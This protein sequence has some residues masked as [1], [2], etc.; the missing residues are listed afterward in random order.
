[1]EE[2]GTNEKSFRKN[3]RVIHSRYLFYG[4][5]ALLFGLTLSRKLFAGEVLY[6]VITVVT[7]LAVILALTLTKRFIMLGVIIPLFLIGNGLFFWSYN[8]FRGKEYEG[9]QAVVGRVSDYIEDHGEVQNLVLDC[10]TINGES[11]RNIW[12][13]VDLDGRKIKVGDILAFESN[14][15]QINLFEL[16]SFS[17]FYHRHN[18]PYQASVSLANV[19]ISDGAVRYDES[20]RSDTKKVLFENMSEKNAGICYAVLFGDKRFTDKDIKTDYNVVGIIH[21]LT[22][23]GLHVSFVVGLLYFALKKCNRYVRF[24]IVFTILLLY[25]ILCGFT[26]SVLRASIM[27]LILLLS[28][29]SGREYDSLSALSLAGF[30]IVLTQPLCALDVGFLMS[31]FS[32]AGIFLI[33]KPLS[34][35]LQKFMP[36]KIASYIALTISAQL[37]ILPFVANLFQSYNFLSVLANLFILPIFGFVFPLLF[38]F[39]ILSLITPVL[40]IVMHAIDWGFK[41]INYLVYIFSSTSLIVDLKPFP[42]VF[43]IILCLGLFVVSYYLMVESVVKWAL[44]SALVLASCVT[45]I[46]FSQPRKD[47]NFIEYSNYANEFVYAVNDKGESLLICDFIYSSSFKK[48]AHIRG[49]KNIDYIIS[50]SDNFDEHYFEEFNIKGVSSTS[51]YTLG[52]KSIEVDK[53]SRYD[54]GEFS[55]K[56]KFINQECVGVEFSINNFKNFFAKNLN[57]SYNESMPT[58][59]WLESQDFAFNFLNKNSYLYLANVKGVKAGEYNLSNIIDYSFAKHGNMMFTFDS[60]KYY[61]RGID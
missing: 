43:N 7:L 10:V 49:I 38:I 35:L 27:A 14:V 34:K 24:G 37:G 13:S 4:F 58:I 30:I 56:Y 2:N 19:V 18:T 48:Y 11:T 44:F 15:A 8:S 42:I 54:Y 17:L 32:V 51:F 28:K 20:I 50:V 33:Y 1:M 55:F 40:G 29:L 21:I 3:K 5:L 26:P 53:S 59:S 57:L 45:L 16:G 46:I 23:S 12:L 6:I 9:E 25:N 60:Q 41:V 47:K 52:D 36:Q 61:F 31:Y 39:F 22:V